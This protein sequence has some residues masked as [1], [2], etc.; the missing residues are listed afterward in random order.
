MHY[1]K[2]KNTQK[3]KVVLLC[4]FFLLMMS[5]FNRDLRGYVKRSK[6]KKTY[7]VIREKDNPECVIYVDGEVWPY[8]IGEKGLIEPGT[9]R[10]QCGSSLEIEIEK[11]TIFI[12][13][14]WG[15]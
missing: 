6:D 11:G 5:C 13:D 12:F 4:T 8:Q 1:K 2:K 3:T 15:P 10:I 9:H 14:Y 7:L